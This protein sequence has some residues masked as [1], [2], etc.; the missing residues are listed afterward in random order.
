M[1]QLLASVTQ[2]NAGIIQA[3]PSPASNAWKNFP[4]SAC[5]GR[6]IGSFSLSSLKSLCSP[7]HAQSDGSASSRGSQCS[8]APCSRPKGTKEVA[9][10]CKDQ[11]PQQRL[12]LSLAYDMGAG[13]CPG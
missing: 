4:G 5:R 2:I 7:N 13:H 10:P 1:A 9:E 6:C 11:L 8:P 3:F 12:G